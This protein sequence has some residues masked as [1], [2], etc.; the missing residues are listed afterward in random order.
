MDVLG[1][2]SFCSYSNIWV[3]RWFRGEGGRCKAGQTR[4]GRKGKEKGDMSTFLPTS[5]NFK[6]LRIASS[7][8]SPPPFPPVIHSSLPSFSFALSP[9]PSF[10]FPPH[11]GLEC[12]ATAEGA[13]SGPARDS[14]DTV[15]ESGTC[16]AHSCKCSTMDKCSENTCKTLSANCFQQSETLH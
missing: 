16:E 9:M 12:G 5:H 3:E 7:S 10:P 8:S 2:N 6:P 1:T 4:E 15:L 13:S 14:D 11:A